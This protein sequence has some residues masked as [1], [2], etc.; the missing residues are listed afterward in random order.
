MKHTTWELGSLELDTSSIL[1]KSSPRSS[2]VVCEGEDP[3]LLP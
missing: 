1:R 3:A 2:A